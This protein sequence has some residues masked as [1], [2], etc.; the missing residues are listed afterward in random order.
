MISKVKNVQGSG[1]WESQHGLF[2]KF[3][4]TFEDGVTMQALH[5]SDKP[6][7][8]G[9]TVEYEV[10]RENEHGKSGKVGKPQEQQ[11]FTQTQNKGSKGNNG[12]FALSYAKDLFMGDEIDDHK[13]TEILAVAETFNDWLNSH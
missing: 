1:T 7:N 10:K 4:Y 8:I 9:E 13:V 3:D 12:S 11:S 6:F 2:Y 5:K